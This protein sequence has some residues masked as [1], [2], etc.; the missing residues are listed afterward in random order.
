MLITLGAYFHT[1][2][3]F[4]VKRLGTGIASP[5]SLPCVYTYG[6]WA[7]NANYFNYKAHYQNRF[8]RGGVGVSNDGGADGGR[9]VITVS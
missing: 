8:I 9:V 7:K 6:S 5:V 1:P 4:R 2:Y 3:V